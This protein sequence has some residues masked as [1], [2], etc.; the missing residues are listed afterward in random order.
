[1]LQLFN[2]LRQHHHALLTLFQVNVKTTVASARLGWLW[3]FIDPLVMM[4]IYYFI[5]H[6]VFQRGGENYHLFVLTGIVVWQ[7]LA[8]TLS[9]SV[10]AFSNNRGI[11]R[12]TRTPMALL[13]AVPAV[14]QLFFT[15]IGI[16]IVTAWSFSSIGWQSLALLPL[17]FLVFCL[18]FAIGL[19]VAVI[20]VHFAD[21]AKLLTYC[22]RAGFFLSPVLYP[23]SRVLEAEGI[24]ETFK[25]LFMANP[26]AWLIE[27]FRVVILEGGMFSWYQYAG[28]L[29]L[30][31]VLMQLGLSYL[32]ASSNVIVKTL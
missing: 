4:A 12:Q 22:L 11:I 15:S 29:A 24:P 25:G 6:V 27:S 21:T 18:A 28:L 14:V 23:A 7:F 16:L 17:L 3:W 8:R 10:T 31:L 30:A 2:D 9:A 32:R 13:V 5:I 19:F 26:A 1:M 20:Q